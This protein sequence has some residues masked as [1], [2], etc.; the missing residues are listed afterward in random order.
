MWKE[1]E[2]FKYMLIDVTPPQQSQGSEYLNEI[3][4]FFIIIDIHDYTL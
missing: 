1:H 4:L 3:T 2:K